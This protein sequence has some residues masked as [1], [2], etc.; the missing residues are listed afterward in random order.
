VVDDEA[1]VRDA[2]VALDA[3]FERRDVDAVLDLCTDDVVFI[4][5]GEGEEAVGRDA[6]VAMLAVLTPHAEG[7]EFTLVWDSVDVDVL[8]D[9]ALLVAWGKAT[10]VT[11]RRTA[12]T[13]Y[14]LTGVLQRSEGRWRW[15]VHHGSEGA[16]W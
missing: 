13:R 4:G 12:T 1:A 15:R 9:V 10:L 8:G 11:L 3:A 5:S 2:L 16:A 14:R 6:L 7:A